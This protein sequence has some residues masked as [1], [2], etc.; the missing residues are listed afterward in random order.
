M[1]ERPIEVQTELIVRYRRVADL[2]VAYHVKCDNGPEEFGREFYHAVGEILQGVPLDRL[3]LFHVQ[4]DDVKNIVFTGR[5]K[6]AN[7][8]F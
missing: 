4:T 3:E 8:D 6:K 5:S 1:S 7:V 2:W